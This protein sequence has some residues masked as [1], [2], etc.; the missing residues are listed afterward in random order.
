MFL[1][2][3]AA[4]FLFSSKL[5]TALI[6]IGIGVGV[7]VQI[8][9]GSLIEGLQEDLIDSTVGSRAHITISSEERGGLLE[10]DPSFKGDVEAFDDEIKVVSPVLEGPGNIDNDESDPVI[11]R[12][13][14]FDEANVIYDF[15]DRLVEGAMPDN[16]GFIIGNALADML[17]VAV[18]D[19]ISVVIPQ[20]GFTP[21]DVDVV[22]IFDLGNRTLNESW[23]VTS[24]STA[25][26]LFENDGLSAYEIQVIDVFAS[27]ELRDAMREQFPGY[28]IDE[29]QSEN[30]DL[31]AGLEGQSISSLMIQIFVM[32]SVVLGIASVLAISVLQKSR[33]LGILKAMGITD[34]KAS[35]IFLFQGM[36]LGIFG[37]VIGISLGITLVYA[38][39]TFAVDA[40]GDPVVRVLIN[41]AFIAISAAVAILASLVASI[42]PARRSARLNVIEVIRNG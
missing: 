38:F 16:D 33:Q 10:D 21:I 27:V 6:M 12:G 20:V 1:L 9:I 35:L 7:S 25:Q 41:P 32:I 8:F 5:Q 22:G 36:I 2:R 3:L 15:E 11:V 4:R 18:G 34:R 17:G 40:S 28:R 14:D 39:S 30:E 26:A 24:L 19:S 31:L 13:F 23:M 37:A 29:W 42:I